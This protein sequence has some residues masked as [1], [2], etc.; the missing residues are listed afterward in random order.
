MPCNAIFV[1][2]ENDGTSHH[3]DWS[4]FLNAFGSAERSTNKLSA[5]NI[6]ENLPHVD[7]NHLKYECGEYVQ[8]HVTE[9][10]TNTMK[11]RTIG[12]IV[13]DPRNLTGRYNFMSLETGREINGRVTTAMP[14]ITD[15]VIKRVEE[16]GLEQQQPYRESKMLKY[17]WRPGQPITAD[18]IVAP[19]DAAQEPLILPEPIVINLPND[20]PNPFVPIDVDDLPGADEIETELP[21]NQEEQG[22]K[23]KERKERKFK[24]RKSKHWSK[25]KERRTATKSNHKT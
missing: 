8:L 24:E 2:P 18:D 5:R 11:S 23:L 20:G 22:G 10:V 21:D 19:A 3:Q 13:L 14:N 17:E 16:L 9:K 4:C 1:L 15:D 25:L 6:I 12:A 7:H